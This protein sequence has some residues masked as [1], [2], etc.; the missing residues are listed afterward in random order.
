MQAEPQALVCACCAQIKL[1]ECDAAASIRWA[2]AEEVFARRTPLAFREN[3]CWST[4]ME[5]YGGTEPMI[6][7][8][9]VRSY[10]R[11]RRL[12]RTKFTGRDVVCCPEDIACVAEHNVAELCAQRR[13]PLCA[14]RW[15]KGDK[16]A[17]PEALTNDNLFGY[18]ASFVYEHRVRFM[19]A[20]AASPLYTTVMFLHRIRLWASTGRTMLSSAARRGNPRKREQ[21]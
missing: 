14:E 6:G 15:L 21:L 20:V 7:S 5:R 19:E 18:M 16:Q 12:A 11:R 10:E 3:W 8:E 1:A 17:I 9:A 4:Y 13:L 2:R